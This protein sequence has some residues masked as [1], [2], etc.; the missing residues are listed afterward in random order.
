MDTTDQQPEVNMR[1]VLDKLVDL[2]N[3]RATLVLK[4]HTI[5][6]E[7]RDEITRLTYEMGLKE[8]PLNEEIETIEQEIRDLMP[9]IRESVKTDIG[10]TIKFRNNPIKRII[11]NKKVQELCDKLEMDI[12]E[13]KKDSGTGTPTI[14]FDD[15]G[16]L[17]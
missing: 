4:R 1:E 5:T 3:R 7:E 9:N 11:D 10:T 15:K 12:D 14:S 8:E 16:L 6:Q 13:L 17:E 2:T